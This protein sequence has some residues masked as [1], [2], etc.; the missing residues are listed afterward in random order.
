MLGRNFSGAQSVPNKA[1]GFQGFNPY[2]AGAKHYGG[3]RNAPNIGNV[4]GDGQAGY[5]ERDNKASARKRALLK[6]LKGQMSGDPMNP[7][8]LVSD[9]TGGM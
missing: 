6:R 8:I 7:N 3:G 2:A 4:S 5:N 1:P 9:W